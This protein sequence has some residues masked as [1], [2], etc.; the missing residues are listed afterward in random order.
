MPDS[1]IAPTKSYSFYL[2]GPELLRPVVLFDS[3][4]IECHATCYIYVESS[5]LLL[6]DV[7]PVFICLL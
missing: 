6:H 2:V 5:S 7:K 3:P 1:M 4:G